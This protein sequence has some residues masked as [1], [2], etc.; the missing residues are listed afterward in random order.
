MNPFQPP[1]PTA[2]EQGGGGTDIS[3]LHPDIIA[4]HILTRLDG[5]TLASTASASFALRRLSS[6]AELCLNKCHSAWPS[7]AAPSITNVISAFPNGGPRAFFANSFPLPGLVGPPAS[8]LPQPVELIS[9]VDI[10]Y[11]DVLIFSGID[12]METWSAWFRHSLFRVDL[13]DPWD[14]DLVPI[15]CLD[16]VDTWSVRLMEDLSL[17]WILIDPASMRAVNLSS[18]KPVF[19]QPR[20]PADEVRAM[21]ASILPAAMGPALCPIMV[22]VGTDHGGEPHVR[23]V[24]MQM[25]DFDGNVLDGEDSLVI[26]QMALEGKRG[27]GVRRVEESRRRFKE[28]L[29]LKKQREWR[30]LRAK[31]AFKASAFVAFSFSLLCIVRLL[32]RNGWTK[33]K[34]QT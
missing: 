13:V 27:K 15:R 28:F 4:T 14:A 24:S 17:S 16:E 3:A 9:A 25:E 32:V 30:K 34:V 10:W 31:W 8:S 6:Q 2:A 23:E 18:Q 1:P 22:T 19:V 29:D 11:K 12:V 33:N 20:W 5:P 26:L 7:T 21:F